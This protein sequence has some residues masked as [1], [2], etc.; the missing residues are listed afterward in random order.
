[1]RTRDQLVEK[2][3]EITAE[4][5]EMSLTG[6]QFAAMQD[7]TTELQSVLTEQT[8]FDAEVRRRARKLMGKECVSE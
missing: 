8:G 1:M 5:H 3:M 7:L 2:A 6:T 4:L